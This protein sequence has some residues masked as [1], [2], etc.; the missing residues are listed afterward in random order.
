MP[1]GHDPAD[2]VTTP[3]FATAHGR[4]TRCRSR[5]STAATSRSTARRRC[6]STAMAPTASRCRRRSRANRLSLVDR[7]FV[8]AIAHVRGGT[9]KGWRWYLDGKRE[10][11]PNTFNDFIA[12][13]A[14]W[15]QPGYTAARPHRRAWRQRRRHADGRG[16]QPA[17]R[18][19]SPA[20]SPTC[21]SSTCSTPCSTTRCRSPR[22]NGPN[23]A[24]RSPTRRRS[25]PSSPTRPTTTSRPQPYPAI[26]ALAGLTDPRVTYWEPAKWVARLRA[27]MTGGGPVLLRTNMDA[28][29]GGAVGPL[30]PAR[31]GGDR[32]RLRAGGHGARK[33]TKRPAGPCQPLPATLAV[34]GCKRAGVLSGSCH[35]ART[36]GPGVRTFSASRQH[37]GGR[38]S[39]EWVSDI[40]PPCTTAR[41]T[42]IRGNGR[43]DFR[44]NRPL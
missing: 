13:A 23:G 18:T 8:Y 5:C 41:R 3:L 7:G 19:C 32:L 36:P 30:R 24:T 28:G 26:L 34:V 43:D 4:R 27:T 44:E 31:R 15:S 9:E 16:R 6:C 35:S 33:L 12:A 39:R 38:L 25:G 22:R 37:G 40:R 42:P 21:R 2:Y 14:R 11:K 20:S 10:K 29:H 17:R 1:S